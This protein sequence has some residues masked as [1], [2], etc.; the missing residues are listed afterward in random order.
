MTADDRDFLDFLRSRFSIDGS[1]PVRVLKYLKKRGVTS[2]MIRRYEVGYIPSGF[3]WP[4]LSSPYDL[5][6]DLL[7]W[8]YRD[9]SNLRDKLFF[10]IKSPIGHLAGGLIRTPDFESKDYSRFYLES[11]EAEA[12]FF[13]VREAM[14][15]IWNRRRAFLCEGVFDLF[16]LARLVDPVLCILTASLSRNQSRFLTRFVDEVV[17]VLDMDEQGKKAYEKFEDRYQSDFQSIRRVEY[18]AEDVGDLWLNSSERQ[19][20]KQISNSV[21]V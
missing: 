11:S 12:R 9:G 2:E 5:S 6:D 15:A 21:S 17:F 20:R 18:L 19:F 7:R 13:G 8:S 1:T 4:D 10:P 14:D 16:P 3:S